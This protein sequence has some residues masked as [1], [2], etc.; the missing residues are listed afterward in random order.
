MAE[1]LA[2]AQSNLALG[3]S[4][5]LRIV[6]HHNDRVALTMQIAKKI[7]NDG[8]IGGIEIAGRLIR[9]QDRRIINKRPRNADTL[10][11]AAREFTG[12]MLNSIAKTN[13][14]QSSLGLGFIRHRMKILRQHHVFNR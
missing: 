12:Q 8:L 5:H 14:F 4:R 6:R 7:R 1:D 9:Q 10:L 2:V 13:P 11:L 3:Q